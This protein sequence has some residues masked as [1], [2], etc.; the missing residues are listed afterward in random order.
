MTETGH[1]L[2]APPARRLKLAREIAGYDSAAQA[3]RAMAVP[4]PTYTQH[5]NGTRGM[6]AEQFERYMAFFHGDRRP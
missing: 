4:V 2:T 3:A 5:E 1:P 6:S